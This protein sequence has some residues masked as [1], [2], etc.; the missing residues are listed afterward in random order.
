VALHRAAFATSTLTVAKYE[1]LLEVPHY[2]FEDDLVVE[3]ADG[4]LAAFA[5]GWSDPRG[6]VAEFEPVGTHP[7]H[8]RRGLGAALIATG[9]HRF[10]AGGARIVQVYADAGEAAAEALYASVG[11]Q[12]RA[13]HQRFAIGTPPQR[14][15]GTIAR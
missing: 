14:A 9:L 15:D 4:S 6:A 7:D 13:F 1:R 3:A 5:L 2:R 11:F 10:F 12:R 8:R